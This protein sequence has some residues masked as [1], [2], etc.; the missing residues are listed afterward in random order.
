MR[1][2][3]TLEWKWRLECFGRL[4]GNGI[5]GKERKRHI[6]CKIADCGVERESEQKREKWNR[7]GKPVEKNENGMSVETSS[8]SSEMR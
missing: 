2:C 7:N 6:I 5:K 3:K 1:K 4:E 8:Q